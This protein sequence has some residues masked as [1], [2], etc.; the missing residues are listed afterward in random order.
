MVLSLWT[1]VSFDVSQ[2][3]QHG[4]KGWPCRRNLA[5]GIPKRHLNAYRLEG[6]HFPRCGVHGCEGESQ[7]T[8]CW[9]NVGDPQL[10][11][12]ENIKLPFRQWREGDEFGEGDDFSHNGI[13]LD[14]TKQTV[15]GASG[16]LN[17]DGVG[18]HWHGGNC[19][20]P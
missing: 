12:E 4:V 6:Q 11:H 15:G 3:G 20:I 18:C 1:E 9:A 19:R 17:G 5:D 10:G 8:R 13:G 14:N 7:I 16:V 2:C